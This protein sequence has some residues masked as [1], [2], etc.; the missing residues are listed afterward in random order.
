MT[1][2]P[3]T[4]ARPSK[5]GGPRVTIRKRDVCRTLWNEC[6]VDDKPGCKKLRT[7]YMNHPITMRR[8]EEDRHFKIP[9]QNFFHHLV[10][11]FLAVQDPFG[12]VLPNANE[13]SPRDQTKRC[14]G[15]ELREAAVELATR[16]EPDPPPKPCP[17][18]C[19]GARRFRNFRT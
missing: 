1:V 12:I 16:R 14:L 4:P 15:P 11:K 7:L 10:K 3:V 18:Y 2:T 19:Q 6:G 8:K 17:L 13:D 9:S 5:G